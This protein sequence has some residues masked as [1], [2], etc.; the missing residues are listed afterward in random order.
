MLLA[1]DL[2]VVQGFCKFVGS[3]TVVSLP[4]QN[5]ANNTFRIDDVAVM[6]HLPWAL[7]FRLLRIRI[8]GKSELRARGQPSPDKA[9][10]L[11][12]AFMAPP[13]MEVWV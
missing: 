5:G 13:S 2:H 7:A 11:A 1:V 12:L 9:D 8:E 3:S 10:A 6:N 4:G